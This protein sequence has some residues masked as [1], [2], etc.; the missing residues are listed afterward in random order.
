MKFFGKDFHSSLP[1]MG[2]R[3]GGGLKKNPF[4][5]L[6]LTLFKLPLTLTLS[7]EGERGLTLCGA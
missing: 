6:P 4:A 7:P 5:D 2:G 3:L 1:P